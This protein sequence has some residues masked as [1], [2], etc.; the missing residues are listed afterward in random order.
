MSA[1]AYTTTINSQLCTFNFNY[2]L[3]GLFRY[4]L[5]R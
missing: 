4:S 1:T 2:A 5:A 3:K